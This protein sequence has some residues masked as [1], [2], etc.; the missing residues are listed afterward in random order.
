V[1]I[2]FFAFVGYEV[3]ITSIFQ[4]RSQ[5]ALLAE[6]KKDLALDDTKEVL[7]PTAGRPVGL[8]EIPSIGLEQMIVQG[9]TSDQT[10]KGPGHDP[11]TPAPG[12]AGNSVIIGRRA[13]YGRPFRDLGQLAPGDTVIVLTRQGQFTYKVGLTRTADF[14]SR[15]VTAPTGENRLTLITASSGLARSETVVVAKLD[16]DGLQAPGPL[17]LPPEGFHPAKSSGVSPWGAVIL[18][19]ELFALAIFGAWRLYRR[20]WNT[21]ITY[22]LTTP[23]LLTLAFLFFGAVDSLLP[24]SL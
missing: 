12:Q 4:S 15:I 9:I 17:Q 1:G 20:G 5:S 11:S 6:F 22:L 19:G 21:P 23:I 18:W 14:G 24:P 10:K 3:F 13:T 8:L 2:L 7:T 16:G